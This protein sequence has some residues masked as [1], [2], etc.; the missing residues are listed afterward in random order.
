MQTIKI[1]SK[2]NTRTV[3]HAQYFS[4]PAGGGGKVSKTVEKGGSV[5]ASVTYSST[6][7]ASAK[8]I[9]GELSESVGV[10]LAASGTK[11]KTTSETVEVTV[12]SGK[13]AFF[14]GVKKFKGNWTSTKCNSGGTS[15]IKSNGSAISFAVPASGAAKCSS[16]YASSSFEYK[17]KAIAC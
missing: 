15:I 16:S 4:I 6:T 2:S 11:T 1:T 10:T 14:S 7:E 13:Y 9:I 8:A 5:T 12:S 3:T 17:A